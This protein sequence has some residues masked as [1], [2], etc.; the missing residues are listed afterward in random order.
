MT[1]SSAVPVIV[2]TTP[3]APQNLTATVGADY[4]TLNWDAPEN[5]GGSAI[6]G[7]QVSDNIVTFWIDVDGE[8]EHTITGLNSETEYTFK[9]RAVNFA[10]HSVE[11]VITV[12]TTEPEAIHITGV[13]LDAD[14]WDIYVGDS[15]SLTA[16]LSPADANNQTVTWTSSNPLVATVDR[17][18]VVN[19]LTAGTT[20]ITVTTNDGG[21][22]AKSIVT[23]G[24]NG[25]PIENLL[26][27]IGL[28]TLAPLG[29]GT[30]I[31]FWRKNR[32]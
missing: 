30:G 25:T 8:Y 26:L 2:S 12:T 9:V 22:T 14:N 10:G 6:I 23:V 17:N 13:S 1:A 31:Y 24:T 16:T 20:I 18:G 15:I 29:T 7:Y 28:G 5:N 27:W 4:V 19:A 32:K 21:F 3:G 11:T